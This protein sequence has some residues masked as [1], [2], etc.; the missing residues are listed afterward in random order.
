[1]VRRAVSLA[2]GVTPTPAARGRSSL[3]EIGAYSS[4]SAQSPGKPGSYRRPVMRNE[5]R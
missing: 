1:M 2:C 3:R 4:D 5:F